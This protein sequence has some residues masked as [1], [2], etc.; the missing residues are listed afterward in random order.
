MA[1]I[2][3]N[4]K[5][6][7]QINRKFKKNQ[8]YKVTKGIYVNEPK[9]IFIYLEDIFKALQIRGTI[10]FK[11]AIEYKNNI[12]NKELFI[13]TKNIKSNITLGKIKI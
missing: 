13:I 9:E 12:T 1:L 8:I 5:N 11:S 3:V 2:V 10:Y 4:E 6:K 7:L